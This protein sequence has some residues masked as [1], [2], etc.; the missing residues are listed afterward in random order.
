MALDG[1]GEDIT[2]AQVAPDGGRSG[3]LGTLPSHQ[4]RDLVLTG[5][6]LS[7]DRV[8]EEAARPGDECLHEAILS[9]HGVKV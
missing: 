1:A 4:R 9:H 5:P 8:P 2:I 7:A 3:R 6:K